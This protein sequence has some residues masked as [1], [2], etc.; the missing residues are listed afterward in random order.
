M[1][2]SQVER[3]NEILHEID[4]LTARL[5]SEA[6]SIKQI[7]DQYATENKSVSLT[8]FEPC[9]RKS[10]SISF[11]GSGYD[12]INELVTRNQK[13]QADKIAALQK[14]LSEL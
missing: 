1:T 4:D 12:F 14:E 9:S 5:K 13:G 10:I 6:E 2:R 7:F 3:A 8:L 11:E